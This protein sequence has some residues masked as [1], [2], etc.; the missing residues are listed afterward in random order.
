MRPW[1]A[2]WFVLAA[3][4]AWAQSKDDFTSEDDEDIEFEAEPEPEPAPAAPAPAEKGKKPAEPKPDPK[5]KTEPVAPTPPVKGP[6]DEEDL[7]EDE[8]DLQFSDEVDDEGAIQQTDM[9]GDD[10]SDTQTILRAP[11]TD[12]AELYRAEQ[13][14]LASVPA[15]E[16]VMAWEAYLETYPN[17]LFRDRITTRMEELEGAAYRQKI[18][19]TSTTQNAADAELLFVLPNH[20]PN[21]N[22]RSKVQAGIDIGV[23]GSFRGIA[24]FEWALKRNVSVHGGF[25]GTYEGWG[26]ELGTRYAFVKSAKSK[27]VATLIADL[28]LGFTPLVFQFRPQIAVGKIWDV[29]SSG[30]NIQL[31]VSGGTR[32]GTLPPGTAPN[33]SI[34]SQI[35]VFGGLHLS[36]RVAPPVAVFFET[37]FD[38]KSLD[39]AGGLFAFQSI[40]LGLRFFPKL[41]NRDDDP[42]QVDVAGH[43]AVG[44]QYTQ[45]FL[46]SVQAQG[47]Y[48]LQPKWIGR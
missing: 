43:V 10:T 46:G 17:T 26:L 1:L 35:G 19:R 40:G 11:G 12:D 22:P 5:A 24:D 34:V 47:G 27:V 30:V 42:L 14:R 6:D 28:R 4:S 38:L 32:V 36:V 7:L 2:I 21:V 23:P 16:E 41:K 31:I 29:G 33:A 15:D 45:Y 8:E 39:R 48:F 18:R 25:A 3:P 9:F 20:L 13:A 37:D 44:S